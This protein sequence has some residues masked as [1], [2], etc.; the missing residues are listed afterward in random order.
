VFVGVDILDL[1]IVSVSFRYAP[2]VI[3]VVIIPV[4]KLFGVGNQLLIWRSATSI[5][6]CASMALAVD[7][8]VNDCAPISFIM[9][10]QPIYDNVEAT[11]H[12]V[13]T[14]DENIGLPIL[15][16]THVVVQFMVLLPTISA[17]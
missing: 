12:C 4:P 1:Y 9:I 2:Y 15:H 13:V 8:A 7:F 3:T 5:D 10:V 11:S 17:G 6:N 16:A 14:V